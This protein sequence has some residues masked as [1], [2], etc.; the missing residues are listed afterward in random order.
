MNIIA[1]PGYNPIVEG[2]CR[3]SLLFVCAPTGKEDELM[4]ISEPAYCREGF[5]QLVAMLRSRS[6]GK[7]LGEVCYGHWLI[8]RPNDLT[9]TDGSP[10]N[11]IQLI[12]N[13]RFYYA[14]DISE[15][16]AC[17]WEAVQ[18]GLNNINAL[19]GSMGLGDIQITSTDNSL[20]LGR[21]LGRTARYIV[22]VPKI[23]ATNTWT[24]S[25]AT[26]ITRGL[27]TRGEEVLDTLLGCL[28]SSGS[29]VRLGMGSV[30]LVEAA[31]RYMSKVRP[32]TYKRMTAHGWSLTFGVSSL[33]VGAGRAL[34]YMAE[35]GAS[36]ETGVGYACSSGSKQEHNEIHNLVEYLQ[37]L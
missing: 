30:P 21:R 16:G 32:A 13:G 8:A 22:S 31:L 35:R 25:L 6:H 36:S 10:S 29:Y 15:E 37:Q 4:A 33:F 26:Y 1:P 7:I 12:R 14:Q 28:P 20:L 27:L 3:S 24:L 18:D 5:S 2:S 19:L 23:F 11:K 34:A 17:H 9:W